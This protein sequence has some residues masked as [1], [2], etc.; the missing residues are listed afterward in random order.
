MRHWLAV[1]LLTMFSAQLFAQRSTW[2]EQFKE[3]AA[4][5]LSPIT[6][7]TDTSKPSWF[8]EFSE[9][10][11]PVTRNTDGEVDYAFSALLGAYDLLQVADV[12]TTQQGLEKFHRQWELVE[13]NPFWRNPKSAGFIAYKASSTLLMNYLLKRMYRNNRVA[14]Y[15]VAGGMTVGYAWLVHRNYQLTLQFPV[16]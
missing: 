13:A 1:F 5:P 9:S 10:A 7:D 16:N 2:F 14:A 12:A 4:P 8:E 11:S 6:Q 3:R 15:I